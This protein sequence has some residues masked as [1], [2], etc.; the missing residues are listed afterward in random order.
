MYI[1]L[2]ISVWL[3]VFLLWNLET[4]L[5]GGDWDRCHLSIR[6]PNVSTQSRVFISGNKIQ[7]MVTYT[8]GG[9]SSA[10]GRSNLQ[11]HLQWLPQSVCRADRQNIGPTTEGTQTGSSEW[12]P[13]TV[14]S[15]RACCTRVT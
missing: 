7:G 1:T 6:L 10:E 13:G 4:A 8:G 2:K 3:G 12:T 9:G 15:G 14:S 11:D 5:A